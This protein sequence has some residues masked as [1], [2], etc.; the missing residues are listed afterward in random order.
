MARTEAEPEFEPPS[1]LDDIIAR[2]NSTQRL[3]YSVIRSEV[4]AGA[5]NFIR[6]CCDQISPEPPE[7]LHGAELQPDG[8]WSA[9][10]LRRAV[11]ENRI[12]E[13]WSEY[14]K[15]IKIEIGHGWQ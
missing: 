8:S 12:S 2:F 10:G 11:M 6:S 5:V 4:G 7:S 9:E 3:V 15:L 13:P 14:Q 1:D